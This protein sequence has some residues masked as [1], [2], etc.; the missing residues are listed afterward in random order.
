MLLK[1][2]VEVEATTDLVTREVR[3]KKAA[4]VVALQQALEIAK[5][6]EV[7]AEVLLNESN[8]QKVLELAGDIKELVVAD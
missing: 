5:E 3:M 7:S 6:I 1:K 2:K 4:D 8:A